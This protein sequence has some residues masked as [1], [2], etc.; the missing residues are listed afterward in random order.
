MTN[1]ETDEFRGNRNLNRL[2]RIS[3][4]KQEE[5]IK[6]SLELGL[7]AADSINDRTISLFCRGHQPACALTEEDSIRA[8]AINETV[9]LHPRIEGARC[10]EG[11][12][13]DHGR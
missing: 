3:Q 12:A 8:E 13:E 11:D 6:R 9:S 1:P 5:E 2:E 4:T 7:E 10:V